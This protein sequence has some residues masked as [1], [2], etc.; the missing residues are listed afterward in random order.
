MG[1]PS[2]ADGPASA[3]GRR[4]TTFERVEE[5]P[6]QVVKR[7]VD[8]QLFDRDKVATGVRLAAKG[9]PIETDDHGAT[10]DALI[11]GVEDAIRL[12]GTPEVTTEAIG[13]AVLERLRELDPVAAVRFASVYLGFDD[14][15]DFER[16]ITLLAK[17]TEPKRH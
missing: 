15:S 10:I 1:R 17:R 11:V 7:S 8:R 9:R 5:T 16:E 6:L 14:L 4:F 12:T 2:G 13:R 3:C